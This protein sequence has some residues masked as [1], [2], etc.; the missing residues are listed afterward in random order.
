MI[1]MLGGSDDV[2]PM[3][4]AFEGRDRRLRNEMYCFMFSDAMLAA[5]CT[6]S[7]W[8]SQPYAKHLYCSESINTSLLLPAPR[9]NFYR[10]ICCLSNP[11]SFL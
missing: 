10:C 1:A 2:L 8:M 7:F 11:R 9:A 4:T 6:G 5:F 3:I